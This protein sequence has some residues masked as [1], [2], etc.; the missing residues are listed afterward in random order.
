VLVSAGAECVL[1]LSIASAG[2]LAALMVLV[3]RLAPDAGCLA[4]SPKHDDGRLV[5][6]PLGTLPP[7]HFHIAH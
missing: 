5:L 2:S 1:A 7:A 4:A 3:S 6:L